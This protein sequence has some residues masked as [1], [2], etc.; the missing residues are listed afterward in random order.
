LQGANTYNCSQSLGN[1]TATTSTCVQRTL[2]WFDNRV[3]SGYNI[4][5]IDFNS[6]EGNVSSLVALGSFTPNI[7]GTYTFYAQS[8]TGLDMWLADGSPG[9]WDGTYGSHTLPNRFLYSDYY[10]SPYTNN[11]LPYNYSLWKQGTTA[12]LEANITYPLLFMMGSCCGEYGYRIRFRGP[13]FTQPIN[14]IDDVDGSPPSFA[15][16]QYDTSLGGKWGNRQQPAVNK[17]CLAN[18]HFLGYAWSS[19]PPVMDFYLKSQEECAALCQNLP[20]CS[21]YRSYGEFSDP[22]G[23]CSLRWFPNVTSGVPVWGESVCFY[24]GNCE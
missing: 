5:G 18:S 4:F 16:Y 21:F 3:P 14:G 15:F 17:G 1:T 19:P 12:T 24:R 20:I 2:S 8:N 10:S 13:G 9:S 23:R 22:P 11:N 7:T 6:L